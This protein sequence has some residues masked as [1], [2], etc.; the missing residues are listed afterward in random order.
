VTAT[1]RFR[2]NFYQYF[3][4]AATGFRMNAGNEMGRPIP[5]SG[6]QNQR[7]ENGC[8]GSRPSRMIGHDLIAALQVLAVIMIENF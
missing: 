5:N 8:L 7:V 4:K 3:S 6:A 1:H 2:H